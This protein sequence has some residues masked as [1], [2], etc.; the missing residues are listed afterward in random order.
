MKVSMIR[1][2]L[3]V[4]LSVSDDEIESCLED[5]CIVAGMSLEEA[6][7]ALLKMQTTF[8]GA[9]LSFEQLMKECILYYTEKFEEPNDI[10]IEPR[11]PLP[12][13]REKLHPRKNQVNKQYWLRTRS[14][15]KSRVNKSIRQRRRDNQ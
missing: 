2:L 10:L 7:N 13:Y 11:E 8:R 15:P 1:K 9:E 3:N 5:V 12:P 14:N 6:V 4:T